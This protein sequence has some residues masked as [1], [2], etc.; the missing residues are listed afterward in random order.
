MRLRRSFTSSEWCAQVT[1]VPDSSSTSVL[2]NGT[3]NG[4]NGM[5]PLGGHTPPIAAVGNSAAEK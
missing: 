3:S 1:V 4:S 2:R 5:M